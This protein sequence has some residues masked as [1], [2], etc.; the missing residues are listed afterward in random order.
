MALAALLAGPAGQA[1]ADGLRAALRLDDD[2]AVVLRLG[3]EELPARLLGV[4]PIDRP[5]RDAAEREIVGSISAAVR[6]GGASDGRGCPLVELFREGRS[7]NVAVI[8]EGLARIDAT[9]GVPPR[10]MERLRLAEGRAK[11]GRRGIWGEPAGPSPMPVSRADGPS[12]AHLL[13]DFEAS[14]ARIPTPSG[15]E[16]RGEGP[17]I[18]RDDPAESRPAGLPAAWIVGWMALPDVG[19]P[20]AWIAWVLGRAV[21]TLLGIWVSAQK[22]RNP[23][24]GMLVCGGFGVLGVVVVACLPAMAAAAAPEPSRAPRGGSRPSGR[25]PHRHDPSAMTRGAAPASRPGGAARLASPL[26][27]YVA[28]TSS[29]SMM[30]M[31]RR[32]QSRDEGVA[33]SDGGL[34]TIDLIIRPTPDDWENEPPTPAPRPPSFW[35]DEDDPDGGVASSEGPTTQSLRS[36]DSRLISSSRDGIESTRVREIGP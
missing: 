35:S 2:G 16:R 20:D 17:S 7:L 11:S 30:P 4:G 9:D 5:W 25:P 34:D 22:R 14:A 13:G 28:A 18:G 6:P 15:T 19:D 26:A 32:R 8:D 31:P 10:L 33:T 12:G 29:G 36:D 21:L 23:V 1:L 3:V 27:E 24:E